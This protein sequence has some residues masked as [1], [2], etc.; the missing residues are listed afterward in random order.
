M[1]EYRILFMGTA[2]FAVPSLIEL[3][4]L[5]QNI[6]SVYSSPPKKANR[7][8]EITNSPVLNYAVTNGLSHSHPLDLKNKSEIEKIKILSPDIIMVIAYGLIIPKDILLIPRLGCFNLHGS[9]LPRWRGAAPI[10][11]ALIDGD[12]KTGITFMKM[13]EGLDT[14]DIVLTKEMIIGKNENYQHLESKLAELGAESFIEFFEKINNNQS[15]IK[16]NDELSTY[17]KKI[18]KSETKLDWSEPAE[19]VIRRINAYSPTPGAW[20]QLKGKRIKILKAS[21]ENDQGEPGKILNNNLTIACGNQSIQPR[22]LKKE[23]KEALSIED[24][25]RGNKIDKDCIIE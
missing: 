2:Q 14:G 3:L 1:K 12:K 7:G 4:N 10:Q 24:F 9:L 23:G 20:F 17:A 5:G 15:F 11:R 19:K 25:L 16:Q 13:D 6:I 8:M 18:E 21:L 22:E